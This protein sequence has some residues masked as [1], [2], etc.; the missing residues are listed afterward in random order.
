MVISTLLP[1]Y[2]LLVLHSVIPHHHHTPAYE[3]PLQY[4]HG[5]TAQHHTH[6]DHEGT[7]EDGNHEDHGRTAHFVHSPEFGNAM[8]KPGVKWIDPPESSNLNGYIQTAMYLWW[9]AQPVVLKLR[10]PEDC[11]PCPDPAIASGGVRGPPDTSMM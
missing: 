3:G 2:M 10:P 5:Y 7:K 4:H 9:P 11:L 1:A 8:V 6:H